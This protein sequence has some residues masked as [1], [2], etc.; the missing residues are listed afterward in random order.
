METENRSSDM[1]ARYCSGR[2]EVKK[3][4]WL[5]VPAEVGCDDDDI[6][7]VYGSVHV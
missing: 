7:D 4:E 3:G 1:K 5:I 6:E 2:T